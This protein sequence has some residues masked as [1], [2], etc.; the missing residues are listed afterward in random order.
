M[1][2][3]YISPFNAFLMRP[4]YGIDPPR[5]TSVSVEHQYFFKTKAKKVTPFYCLQRVAYVETTSAELERRKQRLST[6]LGL[7]IALEM[8]KHWGLSLDVGIAPIWWGLSNGRNMYTDDD[9]SKRYPFWQP[10]IRLQAYY[11]R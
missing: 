3:G 11:W 9:V 1:N 2:V 10:K 6:T 5:H 4:W 7:G 8:R